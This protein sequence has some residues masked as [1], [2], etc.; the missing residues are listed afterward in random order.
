M[1]PP[2]DR[3]VIR[4]SRGRTWAGLRHPSKSVMAGNMQVGCLPEQAVFGGV[5]LPSG[6]GT[7]PLR[8]LDGFDFFVEQP[9]A[10]STPDAMEEAP[11]EP[12][13]K[14][15]GLEILEQNTGG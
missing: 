9:E 7:L 15:V 12:I 4:A 11:S 13:K 2:T 8:L 10:A 3:N 6:D 14:A 1:P 5:N